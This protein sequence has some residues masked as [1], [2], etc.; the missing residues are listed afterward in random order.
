MKQQ[1]IFITDSFSA[2]KQEHDTS[3]YLVEE[4]LN[5]GCLVWQAE[6]P[7]ISF[8]SN[9]II[10]QTFALF[11]NFSKLIEKDRKQSKI[12]EF[13]YS[14]E[15]GNREITVWIRKDPP[16]DQAY[17]QVC[18]LLR[19]L[20]NQ[21]TLINNP[22]SLLFCDEKLL[23]LNFPDL[24]PETLVTNNF[25][26]F[27]NFLEYQKKVVLKPIGGKAGEGILVLEKTDRNLKSIFEIVTKESKNSKIIVQA[28][29]PEI[30][31]G[32]KRIFLLN[33]KPLGALLRFP[34]KND[35][36]ANMA[37]G[38]SVKQSN[39]SEKELKICSRVETFLRKNELHI[40]GLDLIGEK[41]TEI[42][43][44]SPTCL[45]E[46]ANFDQKNHAE[47]VIAWS[48]EWSLKKNTC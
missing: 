5:S 10:I 30:S 4:A 15:S 19:L 24:I 48:K 17:I 2:L 7:D 28:Y 23:A 13:D 1:H 32:D 25:G 29:L 8:S 3:I 11:K 42:N 37:A 36:R 34:Q 20:K 35:Y 39:I 21:V 46:I 44:T 18:Q 9:K 45:R 14:R 22:D 38:G 6:L 12:F 27:K 16:V 40:A 33:G 31:Q 47:T 41:L 43:I 26:E